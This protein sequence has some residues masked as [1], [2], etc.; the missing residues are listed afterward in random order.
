MLEASSSIDLTQKE[1]DFIKSHK[2]IT[3]GTDKEW[4]PYVIQESDGTIT[5]YDASVLKLINGISGANFTLKLGN[6][7]G[8]TKEAK[9]RTIDGLS[10]AIETEEFKKYHLFSKPYISLDKI[11]FTSTNDKQKYSS[12]DD[13]RGKKF[14][15]NKNNSMSIKLAK[16]I[17]D[18]KV[19]YFD[20][21]KE[22][23]QGVTTGQ[24]DAM[25][26]NAAM[27]YLLNKT[28]NPF[29]KPSIFLDKDPLELVFVI[30]NDFPEAISIINKSLEAIGQEQLLGLQGRWFGAVKPTVKT[31][32]LTLTEKNYIK[33][34]KQIKMCINPNAMPF[35]KIK[36]GKHI[37]MAADFFK[38]F[39][40]DINTPIVLIETKDWS[41]SLEFVKN[42]RCDI[43]SMAMKTSD[44]ENYLNFTSPYFHSILV[45]VTKPNI[46]FIDNL[47]QVEGKKIGVAKGYAIYEI[48]QKK[49]PSLKLVETENLQDGLQKVSSG[50]LFGF[51]ENIASV[52]YMYQTSFMHELKI[53]G[54][55]KETLNLGVAVR[56]DDLILLNIFNKAIQKI[57]PQIKQSILNKYLAIKYEQGFNYSLFW[58][59]FALFTLAIVFLSIRYRTIRKYNKKI[60]KQF[61]V[62]DENVLLST[63]DLNN[64]ITYVSKALCKLSGYT[65]KELLGKSNYL[66]V[67]QEISDSAYKKIRDSILDGEIWVG[68]VE[69][70]K[71]DGSI[72]WTNTK[73]TPILDKKNRVIYFSTIKE[74]ITYKKALE[75]ITTTDTLTQVSNRRLLDQS[76]FKEFERARRYKNVFSIIFIDI[77]F[78]KNVNDTYGHQVGDDVLVQ[79]AQLLQENLRNI[80]ILGRWG[81]EEFLIICPE[82]R[83]E[84]ANMLALK[85]KDAIE[86][87]DFPVVHNL[88]C[89]FGV[90]QYRENDEKEDI[91]ERVDKALYRAKQNGRNRVEIS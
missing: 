27:F 45:L 15:V 53:S 78:F 89:S 24:A 21:T 39:Q 22:L 69:N 61:Q 43:L 55:I 3:L 41:Q 5:G 11:I 32:E 17:P 71:K 67:N 52:G 84:D 1:K 10:T 90:T 57:S 44:R 28:G 40:K 82:S 31:I 51:I 60:E 76:I 46:A 63:S 25:L 79:T 72:F 33:H 12:L 66:F 86:H 14:G 68:D 19:V 37:G 30:R 23:I 64:K 36:N 34:K 13:L 6:F 91:I 54:K 70:T 20:N 56:N 4:A 42:R 73:I 58:K 87:F 75:K 83:L 18:I 47:K 7:K 65:Q 88:T 85:L 38:I 81:G 59:I 62:I 26:G 9:N 8:M 48:L 80:D 35:E 29:L 16:T 49:Y 50:E 74:D 77:D 2:V